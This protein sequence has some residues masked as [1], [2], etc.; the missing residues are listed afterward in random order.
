[1]NTVWRGL[2]ITLFGV[3]ASEIIMFVGIQI[4]NISNDDFFI[5][6][7]WIADRTYFIRHIVLPTL[8]NFPTYIIFRSLYKRSSFDNKKLFFSITFFIITTVYAL[9][10]W[11]FIYMS[12]IYVIPVLLVCPLGKKTI[13]YSFFIS[14]ILSGIY[15]LYQNKLDPSIYHA[16]VYLISLGI[17]VISFFLAMNITVSFQTVIRE[18]EAVTKTNTEL[19]EKITKDPL[20]GS[21][22]KEQF[23]KDV[24]TIYHNSIA[25]IDLDAFKQVNDS[26]GHLVGDDILKQ[27]VAM[28]SIERN[29][30][31]RFGGDEFVVL[32]LIPAEDFKMILDLIRED[33]SYICQRRFGAEISFSAGIIESSRG[34]TYDDIVERSDALMYK[35]KSLGK[36]LVYFES[37]T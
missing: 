25:F 26:C 16:F 24:T 29:R 22:N 19:S 13:L 37:N 4:I 32:S 18:V 17:M 20:T 30:V 1:M 35:A 33:F 27:L 8:I 23:I 6:E 7:R 11:G 28:L 9:G 12:I 14:I 15:L 10:H 36:N 21:Y 3:L 2:Y 34:Q 5:P 31:Y